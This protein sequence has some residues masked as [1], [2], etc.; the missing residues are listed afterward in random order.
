M[1]NLT[2]TNDANG[3][4]FSLRP[5]ESWRWVY[6]RDPGFDHR[7]AVVNDETGELIDV[8]ESG[9]EF[10]KLRRRAGG[11]LDSTGVVL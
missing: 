7:I 2:L 11:W 4:V 5:D 8:R 9:T 6:R 10:H 3:T 1:A